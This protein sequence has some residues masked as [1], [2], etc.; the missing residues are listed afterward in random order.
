MNLRF[1]GSM[2]IAPCPARMLREARAKL[3]L[4]Q[5]EL[6]ELVSLSRTRVSQLECGWRS[7]SQTEQEVLCAALGLS[8]ADLRRAA[9]ITPRPNLSQIKRRFSPWTQ[10]RVPKDR[11]SEVRY[12]AAVQKHPELVRRVAGNLKGR[13]DLDWIRVYLRETCFDSYLEVLFSLLL[14][15]DGAQPGWLAPHHAGF[16][17]WPIVEPVTRKVVG[18]RARPALA[19]EEMLLF[20]QVT[21]RAR[22]VT[23]RLDLLLGTQERGRTHWFDVE[24]DGP[25]HDSSTDHFREMEHGLSVVRFG[26]QQVVT[27]RFLDSL[28]ELPSRGSR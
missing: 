16:V 7:P 2:F 6:G 10:Y 3:N 20:P 26:T 5:A 19:W 22:K 23:T 1:H 21:L 15:E 24:I 4:T 12:R 8:P 17:D 13:Q 25:G 27:G 18:H 14:L 9:P 28:R 11:P